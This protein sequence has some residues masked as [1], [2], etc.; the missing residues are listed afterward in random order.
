[1]QQAAQ[2]SPQFASID[3]QYAGLDEVEVGNLLQGERFA[4]ESLKH[5]E[6]YNSRVFAALIFARAGKLEE[7]QNLADEVGREYPHATLVQNYCL[8]SIRAAIKL[9][10]NDPAAAIEILRP[11]QNY[12]FAF[13]D[14]FESLYPVYIRGL[15]YLQMGEGSRA[16]A[17]FQKVLDYPGILEGMIVGSLARLQLARAQAMNGDKAAARTSYEQFLAL[18]KDA[19]T[20][21]PVYKQAKAEYTRLNKH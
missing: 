2:R 4:A 1:V 5:N 8:P 10:Q 7:A 13:T 20:D 11:H 17:E 21:I 12:D 9:R 18:W 14:N 16:A 19:D 3:L 6:D 15:A